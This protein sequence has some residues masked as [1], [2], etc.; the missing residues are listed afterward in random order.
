MMRWKRSGGF[1]L[2]EL[3][4]VVIIVGILAAVA[5]PI[6]RSNV[7]KAAATEGA[8]LLGAVLTAERLYYSEF[9]AYTATGS[10]LSVDAAGNR[11]FT[12]FN[13]PTVSGTTF[14]VSTS[15]TV[16][17]ANGV[18]VTMTYSHAGGASISYSGI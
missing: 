6:Y 16:A 3:M 11:Y 14:T 7:R 12:S 5:I 9:D 8:A 15:S 4:V 2:I 17:P 10:L 18:T 13:N 1:T